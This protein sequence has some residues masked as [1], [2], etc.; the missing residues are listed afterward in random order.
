M[1][2]QA[3]CASLLAALVACG[4]DDAILGDGGADGGRDGG[5]DAGTD[6][7]PGPLAVALEGATLV[8]L[9]TDACFDAVHNG[10]AGASLEWFWGD[11]TR[12]TTPEPRRCHRFPYPGEFLVS[13]RLMARGMKADASLVVTALP[14]PSDPAPASSSP[15]AYDDARDRVW[16]V[17]PDSNS[18]AIL[19]ATSLA[20]VREV[21]VGAHP[22][23]IAIASD[24]VYV[25]C[26]DDGTVH[27]LDAASGD[28]MAPID[29]GLGSEPYGVV[30]DPRGGRVWVSLRSAGAV[31]SIAGGRV[32]RTVGGLVEPRGIAIN[33][34]GAM[35]VT[36]FRS[37]AEGAYVAT[38]DASDPDAPSI[39]GVSR[40]DRDTERDSDTDNNGVFS[41]LNQVV[42]TPDGG[43]ALVPA[44]KANNVT[45]LHRTGAMLTSQTT[46]RAAL[47]ELSFVDGVAVESFRHSF[48]DLDY[49]SALAFR[50]T[51]ARMYVALQGAEAV[52]E[53]D[54]FSFNIT[55]SISD[56]GF[57]PQGLVVSPDG[58]RL[59]VQA[60]LSRA[61]RVYDVSDL[62][63]E[64]APL[65]DISTTSRDPLAPA[66]LEGKR[67][68]YR[69]VDPRMSRTS[70]LSCAS[71][72]LDGLGDSLVWDFTQR[73]EGLRNTIELRGRGGTAHGPLHWSANFDELQDFEHDIRAGQGG[74]GFLS[75]ELFRDSTT[76][77]TPKAGLSPELDALAAYVATLT[78]FGVSP[79][80][81]DDGA[82]L[83][84]FARGEAIFD[85][86]GCRGCHAESRF[87]DSVFD[88]PG[89]PRLH[90]VGTIGPGSGGRL[91]GALT[92]L[93]APTLRGLWRSA[94]YL[95]DGS[96]TLREV[97]TTRNPGDRHGT[98]STLGA[99][100]LDDLET[101][102]LA[103]DDR[104]P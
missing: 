58:S 73:G 4:D 96:A 72:H 101:Y 17:N 81:R 86:A 46:A 9:A 104:V 2:A 29:V 41:F 71:C 3:W 64:P 75:D 61:V 84:A 59:F 27:R 48:D 91:G 38:I 6:A 94:P 102:L 97:L 82:W 95:H 83:A 24:G 23:T 40:F 68:F 63:R 21:D 8:D 16:V 103:L 62:S 14:W 80:R 42:F 19:D 13:V 66:V 79:F 45:G 25:A 90:D 55:G 33:A 18:V 30:A 12:E 89:E 69:A 49:A 26:E 87:T 54:P 35:L 53:L 7:P 28:A 57:A 56:V 85:R 39:A 74:T 78:G 92:G 32:T 44:L 31:V 76:L 15:I 1:I 51:G 47:G 20:L 100:E 93:D 22:R 52:L 43:R 10:G 65:A 88:R 77:G 67:I 99:A 60:F 50:A 98:T 70:Y 37:D 34:T 5:S 36:R 11:E